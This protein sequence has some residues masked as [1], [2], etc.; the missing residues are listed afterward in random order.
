MKIEP[1]S[2][3]VTLKDVQ[4]ELCAALYITPGS[5]TSSGTTGTANTGTSSGSGSDVT[6]YLGIPQCFSQNVKDLQH[7]LNADGFRDA[8]GNKLKEDGIFG[9]KTY[10]ALCRVCLSVRTYGR[11]INI[12]A[13]VQ[14]RVGAN[15]DGLFGEKETKRCVGAYQKVKGL[16]EDCVV[17]KNTMLQL[18]KDYV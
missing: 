2:G 11:Y 1:G 16:V 4:K 10:E 18:V 5:S 13:W 8:N 12:T 7:A 9:P 14:C 17:G 15:P 3:R 6:Y